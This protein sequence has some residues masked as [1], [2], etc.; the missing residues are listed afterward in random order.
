MDKEFV[1]YPFCLWLKKIGYDEPC[2]AGYWVTGREVKIFYF[3]EPVRTSESRRPAYDG[4][5]TAS[6]YGQ[7]FRFLRDN[8]FM[9]QEVRR[10]KYD[11]SNRYSF[12]I[13]SP[14]HEY[15]F[16]ELYD[17]FESAQEECLRRMLITAQTNLER[18]TNG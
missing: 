10:L 9:H 4:F 7:A 15:N 11:N 6:T 3:L 18:N 13:Y 1:P 8:F 16:S 2:M 12:T 14:G 5:V 17:N